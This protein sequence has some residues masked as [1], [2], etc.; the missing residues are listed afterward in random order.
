MPTNYIH[1]TQ[2]ERE[3]ESERERER[4]RLIIEGRRDNPKSLVIYVSHKHDLFFV[5]IRSTSSG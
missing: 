3:R 5:S 2:I 1:K 4:E